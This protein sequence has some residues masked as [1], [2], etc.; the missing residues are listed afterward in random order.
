MTDTRP[1]DHR[2]PTPDE[3]AMANAAD[4]GTMIRQARKR[5]GWK[6]DYLATLMNVGRSAVGQWERGETVPQTRT[7]VALARLLDFDIRDAA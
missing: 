6:Q 5:R 4:I 3:L 1:L 2:A 7:L